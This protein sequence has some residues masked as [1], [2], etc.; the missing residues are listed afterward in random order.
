M[1]PLISKVTI[2]DFRSISADFLEMD[3]VTALVGANESGKTNLLRAIK[4]IKQPTNPSSVDG[5]FCIDK[6][7]DTR[8]LSNSFL[9]QQYPKIEYEINDVI[10]LIN[11]QDLKSFVENNSI[12]TAVITRQGNI[13]DDFSIE[14]SIKI[15]PYI[16]E[17]LSDQNI[18]LA[19]GEKDS[20]T[21]PP[22]SWQIIEDKTSYQVSI[23]QLVAD[24]KLK[25]YDPNQSREFIKSKIKNEILTNIKVFFWTY[26]EKQIIQDIVPITEFIEKPE[27]FPRISDLFK[28][29]GWDKTKISNFLQGKSPST[30]N[31]LLRQLSKNV[32]K[33]IKDSWRQNPNLNIEITHAGNALNILI[34]DNEYG[35]EYTQRSDGLKWF[36]SFL[37]GFRAQ[38]EKFK[39]YLILFDEP[40]LHLHPGG[41]KDILKQINLLAENNQIVYST[42]S[43][44]TLDKRYP[45]RIKLI[46]KEYDKNKYPLTRIKNKIE[47]ED[48]LK[49]SL[50]R[51]VLGYSITD[52]SPISDINLLVEGVFDRGLLQI[53]SRKY[54]S[55]YSEG[56]NLNEIAIIA[57]HGASD[58]SKNAKHLDANGLFCLCLYDSDSAGKSSRDANT[59][60]GK[61]F[62]PLI[63]EIVQV[64]IEIEDI[65]PKT[66]FAKQY[67]DYFL[68]KFPASQQVQSKILEKALKEKSKTENKKEE[69]VK[70]E[71]ET[72]LLQALTAYIKNHDFASDKELGNIKD[73]IDKLGKLLNGLSKKLNS[74]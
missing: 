47:D 30:Y 67:K 45:D 56:I 63:G 18:E 21:L 59:S 22:T 20:I 2:I 40:G 71:F 55:E 1:K 43:I 49:D 25:V 35:T 41:Q 11:N 61:S 48:I 12:E 57:C 52:V 10:R 51:E 29:G 44:F 33:I 65:Y 53:C 68:K 54:Y 8:M 27:N 6:D 3:N 37:I 72:Q 66:L 34:R 24:G 70:H 60:I 58:V 7:R 28:L 23:D 32:T 73:L 74:R 50:L 16:V 62:K 14:L 36:L 17:N 46:R 26:E 38:T 13:T 42:H 9:N 5:P 31:N 4:F 15:P 64:A 19:L 69:D 39:E